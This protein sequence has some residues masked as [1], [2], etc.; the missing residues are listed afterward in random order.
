MAKEKTVRI[1]VDGEKEDYHVTGK[2]KKKGHLTIHQNEGLFSSQ[3][4]EAVRKLG[5]W[6][7]KDETLGENSSGTPC[8][9]NEQGFRVGRG[10]PGPGK[11]R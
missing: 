6:P 9:I 11:P 1:L 2:T 3:F 8:F 5:R 10:G 7:H 4:V